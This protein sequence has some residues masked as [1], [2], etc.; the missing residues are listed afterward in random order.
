MRPRWQVALLLASCPIWLI[1]ALIYIGWV[2]AGR[3]FFAEFPMAIR[4]ILKGNLK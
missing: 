1:P 4:Y 2:E 3:G